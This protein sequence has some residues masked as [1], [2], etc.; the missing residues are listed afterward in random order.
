M[1]AVNM[2]R[3]TRDLDVQVTRLTA[4]F[5]L[6][7]QL[8]DRGHLAAVRAQ[9]RDVEALM[10]DVEALVGLIYAQA[11]PHGFEDDLADVADIAK[12]KR[13]RRPKATTS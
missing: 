4:Y 10:P 9:I 8:A 7:R 1:S 3:V 11:N 13:A 6:A 12:A 5:A 2:Q